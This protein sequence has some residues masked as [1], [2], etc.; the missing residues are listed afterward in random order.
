MPT[1]IGRKSTTDGPAWEER[2]RRESALALRQSVT[3]CLQTLWTRR[4]RPLHYKKNS[5]NSQEKTPKLT[6]CES[7]ATGRECVARELRQHKKNNP[8]PKLYS[9]Q[10]TL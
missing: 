10:H 3:L 6:S 7:A 5:S 9:G 1:A 4:M 8:R 2:R